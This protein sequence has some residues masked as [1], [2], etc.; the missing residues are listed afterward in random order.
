MVSG[1]HAA[2]RRHRGRC[3]SLGRW[4]ARSAGKEEDKVGTLGSGVASVTAITV[5][6]VSPSRI[7]ARAPGRGGIG[8]PGGRLAGIT[9]ARRTA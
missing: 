6:V 4:D 2:S 1:C 5:M 9:E 7:G 3:S 8:R